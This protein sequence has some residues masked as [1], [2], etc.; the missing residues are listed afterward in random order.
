MTDSD[1]VQELIAIVEEL[2]KKIAALDAKIALQQAQTVYHV[3][4]WSPQVGYQ[5]PTYHPHYVGPSW[6]G[7]AGGST[8]GYAG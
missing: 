6:G 8:T 7:G 1:R 3:H 2:I 4:S 5:Q